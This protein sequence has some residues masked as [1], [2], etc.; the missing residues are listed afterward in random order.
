MTVRTP[1]EA[2]FESTERICRVSSQLFGGYEYHLDLKI[3][4]SLEE[5]VILVL[6]DLEYNLK[7]LKLDGLVE[8]MTK[9]NFHIHNLTFNDIMT[10]EEIIYICDHQS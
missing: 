8:E 1:L 9:R 2:P 6:S 5:I 7:K 10:K 3:I 4:D